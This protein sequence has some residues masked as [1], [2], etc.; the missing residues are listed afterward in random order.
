MSPL[1][2]FHW[3]PGEVYEGEWND[4]SKSGEGKQTYPD[5]TVEEGIWEEDAFQ[6]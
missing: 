3:K 1:G 2:A 5:G 4:G 6:G